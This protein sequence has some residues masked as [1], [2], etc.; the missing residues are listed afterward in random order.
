MQ[1]KN[2]YSGFTFWGGFLLFKTWK[3]PVSISEVFSN[4]SVFKSI[5]DNALIA[6][7]VLE[8]ASSTNGWVSEFLHYCAFSIFESESSTNVFITTFLLMKL[9]YWE[10]NEAKSKYFIRKLYKFTNH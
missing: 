4:E 8:I 10:K 1:S 5:W 7:S 6:I 3:F 9:P 2:I